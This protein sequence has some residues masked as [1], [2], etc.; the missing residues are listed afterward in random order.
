MAVGNRDHC[1]W[2]SCH[3]VK[4]SCV[5]GDLSKNSSALDRHCC[6]R[7]RGNFLAFVNILILNSRD[8]AIDPCIAA[9]R[10]VSCVVIFACTCGPAV[11]LA[12]QFT[13]GDRRLV[14]VLDSL[15]LRSDRTASDVH[16][17]TGVI[18][19]CDKAVAQITAGHRQ[20]SGFIFLF[21]YVPDQ[22]RIHSSAFDRSAVDRH[23]PMVVDHIPA[24]AAII[25]RRTALLSTAGKCTSFQR[26]RAIVHQSAPGMAH[27]VH[28]ARSAGT[29]VLNGQRPVVGNGMALLCVC[30]GMSIQV[31]D[32]RFV[33]T[34]SNAFRHIF[35]QS[36]GIAFTSGVDGG[37][38]R[39]ANLS[40]HRRSRITGTL[41]C[42]SGY[43]TIVIA[44]PAFN[45]CNR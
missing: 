17:P 43:G 26:R 34:N 32:N 16:C 45:T 44:Y 23:G 29:C 9:D 5:C 25:R 8:L 1:L 39:G 12:G 24:V 13:A 21:F 14:P 6:S 28:D 7:I 41:T 33:L 20:A 31:Q 18:F 35:Q 11:N 37:T 2:A 15:V 22:R 10:Q 3:L 42:C 40:I 30:Q 27:I 4:T 19:E 36:H 38:K